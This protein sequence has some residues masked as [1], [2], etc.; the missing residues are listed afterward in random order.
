MVENNTVNAWPTKEFFVEM[1]TRDVR[2]SMAILDLIDNCVDG[3]LKLRGEGSF[4]G[5]QI[6]IEFD[7]N[8]FVIY[9]NCGGIDLD[10][11]RNHAFR[12]GRPKEVM[13]IPN[14]VGRFG[15]G[16]KRAL[17]KI[18]RRFEIE[19][20][21]KMERYRI[22]G[23]VDNWLNR[24]EWD[25]PIE[26]IEIFDHPSTDEATGTKITVEQLTE[27][28]KR[29]FS[30]SQNESSLNSDISTYHQR[31]IDNE[32]VVSLNG[33]TIP[34]SRLEFLVSTTPLLRP[35]Y[36]EYE[37]DGV[38]VRLL[39][40]VGESSPHEAGW[41]IY[42]NGRKVL[43]ADRTRITGWG[44]PNMTPRFHN[45]YARF[46]GVVF[47]D[48]RDSSLLPW[49]TT[50]DGVDEGSPVFSEAYR[51]M[52][53]AMKPVLRFLDSVDRENDKPEGWR[54]LTELLEQK[55]EAKSINSLSRADSFMYRPPPSPPGPPP[56]R[57]I[58]IQYRRP[59][60]VVDGVKASL[61]ITS[62]RQA[63]E[64]TFD[65]YVEQEG[66]DAT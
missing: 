24:E 56:E 47:F 50:K 26:D 30:L 28:T 52:V 49:N 20:S 46:R 64:D 13:P 51:Y 40:G 35:L 48:N 4:R 65:Y 32:L 25:F 21:T 54:L 11:A 55:A 17:F 41:Y 44:E 18:G 61:G 23:D 60:A 2:L 1:L 62:A 66:I 5:L 22:V 7:Q 37:S 43:G 38:H 57:Q 36:R 12:F 42:C 3:A 34:T 53:E 6:R 39:A 59:V 8:R 45:Q 15:V 9:D 16:M 29:W 10:V 14:S 19:T 58:S 63:G 27:E 33:L 31:Y